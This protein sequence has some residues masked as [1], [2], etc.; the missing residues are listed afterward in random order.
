MCQGNG[1]GPFLV[2]RV[3]DGDTV[4][5][6]GGG[7]LVTVR[8]AGVDAPELTEGSV[9]WGL[10]KAQLAALVLNAEV[11]LVRDPVQPRVDAYGRVVAYVVRAVDG[12]DINK[13]MVASGLCS[14]W[15]RGVHGRAAEFERL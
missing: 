13:M 2:V 4:E 15:R 3:W 12:A 10:A 8:L 7:N 11:F 9:A 14:N 1:E 5:V 6:A